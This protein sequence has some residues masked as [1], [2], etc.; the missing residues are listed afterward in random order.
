M[1][2]RGTFFTTL[3]LAVLAF[4]GAIVIAKA[5]G[6]PKLP[7]RFL[8]TSPYVVPT[9][10]VIS[11]LLLLVALY[12]T[13]F[14][15]GLIL[16]AARLVPPPDNVKLPAP[17]PRPG[18]PIGTLE[19]PPPPA[20][21]AV[22]ISARE[23]AF[24]GVPSAPR[25]SLSV[26]DA[27]AGDGLNHQYPLSYEVV[28]FLKVRIVN[29][30]SPSITVKRWELK[31]THKGNYWKT[32]Y[33]KPIQQPIFFKRLPERPLGFGPPPTVE[34]I[35]SP[36]LDVK[37][38]KSGLAVGVAEEGWLGFYVPSVRLHHVFGATFNLTAI[39]DLDAESPLE[40]APGEWLIPGAIDVFQAPPTGLEAPSP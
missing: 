3:G 19:P 11:G 9:L 32:A 17:T 15:R 4:L 7:Y 23:A 34:C 40:Q 27:I 36:G 26:Q 33:C 20:P 5:Q 10:F 18:Q 1:S 31:L 22:G 6:D 24:R 38:S 2:R 30:T 37:T 14:F 16:A 21:Q 25:L 28:V 13:N 39:D 12:E 35:D 29:R 8:L